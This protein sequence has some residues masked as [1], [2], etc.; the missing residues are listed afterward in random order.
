MSQTN[1]GRG[2]GSTGGRG[3]R[4]GGRGPGR[5]GR[6]NYGTSGKSAQPKGECAELG[7]AVYTFGDEKQSE[8]FNK[9]TEKILNYIFTNFDHGK[10]V[11][12]SLEKYE[13]YDMEQWRP[14]EIED[15][16]VLG[17]VEKMI[18]QQEV[19]DYVLR[20]NKFEDNMYKAFGLIL[21][22]CTTR[23][24]N[25]LEAKKDWKVIKDKGDPIQLLT[26]I[27]EITQNFQDSKY[28]IATVHKAITDF[29]MIKQ[30]EKEGLPA[31]IKRF[32]CAQEMLEQHSGKMALTEHIKRMQGYND[33]RKEEYYE[34]A[35]N[36]LL[37]YTFIM[38]SDAKRAGQLSND[39]ANHYALGDNKYPQDL[40]SATE[41]VSNYNGK[42][43]GT[44][45]G[46]KNNSNNAQNRNQQNANSA[47]TD[48]NSPETQTGF[49]QRGNRNNSNQNRGSGNNRQNTQQNDNGIICYACNEPGHIARNCPLIQRNGNG[50]PNNRQVHFQ[51]SGDQSDG[52]QTE[53]N[54]NSEGNIFNATQLFQSQCHGDSNFHLNNERPNLRNK[55]LL[56]NQS[57]ADIFCNPEYLTNVHEVKDTLH[58]ETNGGM[59]KCNKKGLLGGYGYV[60][61]NERAIANIIGLN[62]AEK[63]GKFDISYDSKK[64]F[65]MNNKET[66][67]VTVFEKDQNGLH[68]AP[69]SKVPSSVCLLSTVEENKKLYSKRQVAGAEKAKNLYKV[70]TY[71]SIRDYKH[72]VQS[73][74]IKNCPVTIEDIKI[75]LKIFGDDVHALKGKSTRRK[76]RVV[77]NDYVE[78]PKE[79]IEAHKGVI[80]FVDVLYIDGVTF[81]LTLSKNIRLITIRYIKDRKEETLLEAVDETF[82]KY[83]KAGFEIKE[84]HADNEFQ[85]LNDHLE[86][87]DITPNFCAAQ[88]HVPEIERLV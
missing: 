6:G 35:Y 52:D 62:N 1:G 57:T 43:T 42:T 86:A 33:T 14:E 19:R 55:L 25:K 4:F 48:K 16:T 67:K 38:G 53:N 34:K 7:D 81:L 3:Q 63:T 51:Q 36:Q 47:E 83:N 37:A 76:P 72:V 82:M 59:L 60:W 69:L 77:V 13:V 56:D 2:R 21:G 18:I 49:L 20:R 84:F 27:K 65:I 50:Q 78:I 12:E 87:I 71:P 32:K 31:Y 40:V 70:I 23:L 5:N 11:K 73:N 61:C 30:G 26:A 79:F 45:N 22:Q 85:C 58:L 17:E 41:T 28:P 46:S 9:T 44:N 66:G 39:L 24:K 54:E 64:G 74:Q 15:G 68:V 80:L 29:F 75:W 10:Y 8:K 88:E